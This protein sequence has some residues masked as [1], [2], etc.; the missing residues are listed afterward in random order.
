M[1]F[2]CANAV[3]KSFQSAKSD[4]NTNS[5]TDSDFYANFNTD[6]Y[7]NEHGNCHSYKYSDIYTDWRTRRHPECD[8][9]GKPFC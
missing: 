8:T 4:P 6:S 1:S 2:H 7:S 3:S 9:N 5:Y